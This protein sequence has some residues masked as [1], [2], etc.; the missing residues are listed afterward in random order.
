M[1]YRCD[2]PHGIMFH[3]FHGGCHH[4]SPGSIC[5]E[6]LAD[7]I[8]Y[9]GRERILEPAEWIQ[10]A[11]QGQLAPGDLCLTFDDALLCQFEIALPVLQQYDLRAFWFVYSNVFEGHISRFEVY[12]VFRATCFRDVD[13]FYELFFTR[14]GDGKFAEQAERACNPG[15]I[16]RRRARYP[17][18]SAAD[19]QFRILRDSV[20]S[21]HEYDLM[22][23]GLI[24]ERGQSLA[25]LAE[26]LWINNEQLTLLRDLGHTIGLHS[27][28]HPMCLGQLSPEEQ[29]DQYERN[30]R[31]LSSITGPPCAVA[32][33]AGSYNQDTLNLLKSMG[34]QCGFRSSM[35][36]PEQGGP[37]S[38]SILEMGREDHANLMRQMQHA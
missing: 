15:E 17:F 23:Q 28:S 34:I 27:Y 29:Y 7:L 19:V 33:P 16:A 2:I 38:P 20:L 5:G 26:N 11:E 36:P 1:H 30:Y 35:A 9:V 10:R 18:Y 32:H 4:P 24:A 31:H 21:Q 13:E 14:V 25:E 6:E 12:R 8:R 3:H 22:M 37:I